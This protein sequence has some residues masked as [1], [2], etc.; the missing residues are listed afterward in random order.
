MLKL[1]VRGKRVLFISDTHIPY[2]VPGYI[3]FLEDLKEKFKPEIVIHGGDEVDY[4][5]ISFHKSD[6]DLFSA[7]HELKK[8][9]EEI[10]IGL[11]RLFPKMYLL[12]SNHGSLIHRRL[13]FEGIPLEVLKPLKELYETPA[14]SWHEHILLRTNA[15]KVYVCHGKSGIAGGLLRLLGCSTVEFHYHTM[16]HIT[17]VQTLMGLKF[18]A[19]GGCLA[20]RDSMAMAYAKSNLKQFCNG[21]IGLKASGE[22]ILFPYRD[23]IPPIPKEAND[24]PGDLS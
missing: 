20:D 22:P 24:R 4:H 15:G 19:H 12:D 21:T 9:K 3:P 23:L 7:G 14:W 6:H 18:S 1:D 13:K 17:Y 5:A 8:A 16:F 11:H 10:A 2:S